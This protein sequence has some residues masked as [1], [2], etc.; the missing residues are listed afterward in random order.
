MLSQAEIR[1][2]CNSNT[3]SMH[4]HIKALNTYLKSAVLRASKL[5]KD[6]KKRAQIEKGIVKFREWT[7]KSIIRL[8]A[9]RKVLQDQCTHLN[10]DGMPAGVPCTVCGLSNI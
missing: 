10:E 8:A 6:D 2:D 4:G 9:E 7:E 1:Y 5:D 3:R